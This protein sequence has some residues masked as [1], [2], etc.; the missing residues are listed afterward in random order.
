MQSAAAVV[1]DLLS[2]LQEHAI[3]QYIKAMRVVCIRNHKAYDGAFVRTVAEFT[4][5]VTRLPV[6][7]EY[8]R[9]RTDT[10]K[11]VPRRRVAHIL[12]EFGMCFDGLK[13]MIW[14]AE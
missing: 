6:I 1:N 9:I 13:S 11:V 3:C 14:K 4:Q 8:L 7:H 2:W 10:R 12:H 5:S